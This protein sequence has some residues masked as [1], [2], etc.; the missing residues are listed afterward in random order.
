MDHARA[1]SPA[2]DFDA[3]T[4]PAR[5]VDP[6]IPLGL[7]AAG[8]PPPLTTA[9][10]AA[11]APAPAAPATRPLPIRAGA[12]QRLRELMNRPQGALALALLALL[13]TLLAAWGA[14]VWSWLWTRLSEP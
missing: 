2:V 13:L 7:A 4:S 14:E 5:R 9:Q 8:E 6:T 12:S 11:S 10:L 3:V 1:L